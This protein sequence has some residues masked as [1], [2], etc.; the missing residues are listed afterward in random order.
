[1]CD[2]PNAA[3][4]TASWTCSVCTLSHDSGAATSSCCSLCGTPREGKK[5]KRVSSSPIITM[6]RIVWGGPGE[7]SLEEWLAAVTPNSSLPGCCWIQ[8]HNHETDSAGYKN[9]HQTEQLAFRQEDYQEPLDTIEG[10]ICQRNR[11]KAAEKNACRDALLKIAVTKHNTVGKWL[12]FVP[13]HKADDVWKNIATATACGKLG[14]SAKIAPVG[15]DNA[16]V[17]CCVYVKDFS[18]KSEV[19]RVLH[20]LTRDMKLFI[21]AG[22]KPDVYTELGINQGNPWRLEPTIYKVK[23]ALE[24]NHLESG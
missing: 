21:K 1:M 5:R 17:V 20:A 16:P 10:I 3:A 6:G 12:L 23:E 24:W 22:F 9:P 14:C 15:M 4:V 2:T 13:P 7:G 11:V 8:I 18:E 19:Q